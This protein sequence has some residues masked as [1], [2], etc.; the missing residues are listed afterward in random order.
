MR[1]TNASIMGNPWTIPM[2]NDTQCIRYKK[3]MDFHT[4][5]CKKGCVVLHAII[6][7]FVCKP[8]NEKR[9]DCKSHSPERPQCNEVLEIKTHRGPRHCNH[10][11]SKRGDRQCGWTK[12]STADKWTVWFHVIWTSSFHVHFWLQTKDIIAFG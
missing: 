9:D 5:T 6:C 8:R 10:C 1:C 2:G 4:N 3:R 7:A 12:F 11:N